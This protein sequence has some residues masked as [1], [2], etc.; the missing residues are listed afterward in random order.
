MHHKA[1]PLDREARL[2]L[3]KLPPRIR[4]SLDDLAAASGC[5]TL[6]IVQRFQEGAGHAEF[7]DPPLAPKRGTDETNPVRL[8]D[9]INSAAKEKR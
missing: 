7:P 3:K 6:E 4:R 5:L 1:P 9:S 2:I 8:F